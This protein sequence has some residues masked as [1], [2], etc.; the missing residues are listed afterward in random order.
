[1]IDRN[2]IFRKDILHFMKT[3]KTK[4][5]YSMMLPLYKNLLINTKLFLK[6]F[7]TAT[8]E[9]YKLFVK[10]KAYYQLLIPTK[11]FLQNPYIF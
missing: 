4:L 3:E 6:I 1:M 7:D 8:E 10:S 11:N 9:N 2:V 5:I